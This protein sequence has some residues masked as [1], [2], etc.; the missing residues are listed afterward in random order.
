MR[1]LIVSGLALTLIGVLGAQEPSAGVPHNDATVEP[2]ANQGNDSAAK[3]PEGQS[4]TQ[5]SAESENPKNAIIPPPP[6]RKDM[7]EAKKDF[8]AGVKL[9]SSG[10]TEAAFEQFEQASRLDPRNVEYV[11]AREFARQQLVMEALDRGNKAMQAKNELV[12]TAEF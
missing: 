5:F 7:S 1:F 2:T 4:A 11:T 9:K 8:K 6:S 10:Q 3:G 12:A